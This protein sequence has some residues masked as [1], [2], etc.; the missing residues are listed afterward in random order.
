[1]RELGE[2]W[3]RGVKTRELLYVCLHC[4]LSAM[5][6]KYA[7][8]PLKYGIHVLD[9]DTVVFLSQNLCNSPLQT[10][11]IDSKSPF[12]SVGGSLV[13]SDLMVHESR[14]KRLTEELDEAKGLGALGQ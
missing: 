10:H 11:Q 9:T 12:H 2:V 8:M 3:G 5:P 6:F 14:A 4:L 7:A 1:M 13:P